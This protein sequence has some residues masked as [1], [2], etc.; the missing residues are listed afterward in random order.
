M[1]V[2]HGLHVR[3]VVVEEQ[4]INIDIVILNLHTMEVTVHH[5]N[6]E[7]KVVVHLVTHKDVVQ[8]HMQEAG[9][10]TEVVQQV[11]VEELCIDIVNGIQIMMD[12][13]VQRNVE[14]P[15][16]THIHVLHQ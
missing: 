16:V 3:Q 5:L 8:V 13:G 12:A 9:E 11:V 4:D 14:V 7:H 15:H 6:G 10:V 2:G 1:E